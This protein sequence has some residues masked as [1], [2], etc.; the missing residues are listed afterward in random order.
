MLLPFT[1][2]KA[3]QKLSDVEEEEEEEEIPDLEDDEEEVGE[4]ENVDLCSESQAPVSQPKKQRKR[5]REQD[6]PTAAPDEGTPE[7]RDNGQQGKAGGTFSFRWS[8]SPALLLPCAQPDQVCIP[9]H[10]EAAHLEDDA[11]PD[12]WRKYSMFSIVLI[13]VFSCR[14]ILCYLLKFRSVTDPAA[15]KHAPV[16]PDPPPLGGAARPRATLPRM[17]AET[18]PSPSSTGQNGTC[19]DAA[20]AGDDGTAEDQVSVEISPW[21]RTFRLLKQHLNYPF[22]QVMMQLCSSVRKGSWPMMTMMMCPLKKRPRVNLS[23]RLGTVYYIS[24]PAS[25]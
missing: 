6:A 1:G 22:R 10:A 13:Y 25:V 17:C 20:V 3:Q 7:L 24:P 11:T 21:A 19:D 15:A 9:E 12:R 16:K 14:Q 2:K 8:L 4:E 23:S 18:P 5:R